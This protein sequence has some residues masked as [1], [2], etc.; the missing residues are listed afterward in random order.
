MRSRNRSTMNK[1][2]ASSK[3]N[4]SVQ[5]NIVEVEQTD[6]REVESAKKEVKPKRSKFSG[7][8]PSVPTNFSQF[9]IK[10]APV[11][12]AAG[13]VLVAVNILK[14]E[15][16]R[17]YVNDNLIEDQ[18]SDYF[19]QAKETADSSFFGS[20][21]PFYRTNKL[22]DNL[23]TPLILVNNVDKDVRLFNSTATLRITESRPSLVYVH[24]ISGNQ[25]LV[26]SSG[27]AYQKL[28]EGQESLGSVLVIDKTPFPAAV[29]QVVVNEL[30]IR[31]INDLNGLLQRYS[32]DLSPISYT[33]NS[34][35]RFL[36]LELG[37]EPYSLLLSTNRP[38]DSQFLAYKDLIDHLT[39]VD[40]RIPSEYIDLRLD[41]QVTYK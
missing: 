22:A 26:D 6:S 21:K 34:S 23:S 39:E 29:G 25:Y 33:I 20:L 3:P 32:A 15:E 35:E 36:E 31:F 2:G 7:K 11:F 8:L 9:L 30:S 28:N 4:K 16:Y 12:I 1:T 14:I 27:V 17:I 13:V 5:H 10:I 24:S 37:S 41:G 40:Q 38:V 18:S 19:V